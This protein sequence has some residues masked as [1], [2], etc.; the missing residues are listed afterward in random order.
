M[1]RSGNDGLEWESQ[2]SVKSALDEATAPAF[3]DTFF[4]SIAAA[5]DS[6]PPKD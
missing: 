3:E 5:I 2:A 1:S 6:M 4:G